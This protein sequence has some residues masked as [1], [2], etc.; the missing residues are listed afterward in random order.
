MSPATLRLLRVMGLVAW[1]ML[2]LYCCLHTW[3]SVS[4]GTVAWDARAYHRAWPGGL[5]DIEPGWPD[6]YNYSPLFAQL[7]YPLTL[8]P[9]PVFA[10]V[11][12]GA[13]LVGVL[14]LLRP[15][16]PLLFVLGLGLC[17]VQV[18]SGNIDW[19]LAVVAVVGL[20]RSAAAGSV[21]ACATFTKVVPTLG[22]VWFLARGA[23]RP[24]A[25]WG[26]TVVALVA[27]SAAFDLQAWRDWFTF[28][29][30]NSAGESSSMWPWVPPWWT[31]LPFAVALT[32]WAARTDRPWWVPVAMVLAA[33]VPG[34]GPL[35]LLM[36][37]PRLL[38]AGR[39]Q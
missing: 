33:P 34:T 15:L 2:A 8:L 31:R 27:V 13:A 11:M 22:P 14:W 17:S 23:W 7:A 36:A 28:L 3:Q 20:G 29:L 32:V 4:A 25:A 19:L 35:A 1:A 12:I 6:A 16:P 5:Y 21:W 38:P 9:W 39:R 30:H 37:V 26:V 18:A 10:G 24:L